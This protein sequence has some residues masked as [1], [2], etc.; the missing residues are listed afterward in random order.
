MIGDIIKFTRM[1]EETSKQVAAEKR[2]GDILLC[3]VCTHYGLKILNK[4]HKI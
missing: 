1:S 3:D 4:L 2:K